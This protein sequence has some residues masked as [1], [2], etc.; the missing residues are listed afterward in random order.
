MSGPS[1][2]VEIRPARLDDLE[3]VD[4]LLV[5]TFGNSAGSVFA[6][7]PAEVQLRLRRRLRR[8]AA[9]PAEGLLVAAGRTGIA[10]VV[11]LAT[12]ESHGRPPLAALAAL[13]PLG[14]LG[15]IR[16][17]VAAWA[18]IHRP[19]AD[20]VYLFGLA[21]APSH[22]RQGIAELLL[23]R[24]EEEARRLGKTVMSAD[25][26]PTNRASL[27]LCEKRGFGPG[28]PAGRRW[29]RLILRRGS[30]H[31]RKALS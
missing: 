27:A 21:V 11:L 24:A 3:A 9:R 13:R 20:E 29:R 22:R 8:L 17:C 6:G 15:L 23:R 1:S 12:A 18:T 14:V 28:E 26:A 25:V 31:L 10:G 2:P 16:F 7:V 5:E 4:R 30:V 19:A